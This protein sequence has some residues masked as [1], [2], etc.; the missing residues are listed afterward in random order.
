[1]Y[2]NDFRRVIK[3]ESVEKTHTHTHEQMEADI[4]IYFKK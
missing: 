1:M 2:K 4:D 3:Q